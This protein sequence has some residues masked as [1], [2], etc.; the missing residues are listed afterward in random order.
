[1]SGERAKETATDAA[2]DAETSRPLQWL[3]RLGFAVNGLLH[4]LVGAIAI[5]ITTGSGG[6]EADQ[7]GALQ[8]L[9]NAPGGVFLLWSVVV[10]M[11]ALGIWQCLAAFLVPGRDPKRKWAHRIGEL[12]KGIVY[13]VI[14]VTAFTFAR[15]S[16]SSSSN[17]TESFSAKLLAAPGGVLLLAVI[18]LV[19]LVIGAFFI[20]RGATGKFLRD[21]HVPPGAAG[22]AVTVL[23][24]V[25]YV[26][27]G[28]AL[29]VVGVLF[30]VGAFT[31]DSSK[32][33]GLD[34][35]LKTLAQLP[36]GP[37]ILFVVGVGV[38]AYGLYLFARAALARL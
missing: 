25:G 23:G 34:A 12:S 5:S 36:Y 6:G 10:G 4:I 33:T 30:L 31:F 22:G 28:I 20:W 38:I 21:I 18:G 2:R 17:K 29:A 19:V 7:S 1:V 13:F 27:K 24:L 11:A 37:I 16:S 15:G 8:H 26:A 32:A 3:A 9:A 14:A 35:A